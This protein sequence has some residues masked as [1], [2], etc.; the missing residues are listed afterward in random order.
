ML[1]AINGPARMQDGGQIQYYTTGSDDTVSPSSSAGSVGLDPTVVANLA[2]SLSLF[3]SGLAANIQLLKD[4]K[5]QIKLDTTNVNVTL[6]GESFLAS[7]SGALKSELMA[8][9]GEKIKVYKTALNQY[10]PYLSIQD[11]FKLF[12]F[13]FFIIFSIINDFF[14]KP[15]KAAVISTL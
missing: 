14:T 15:S 3:N 8:A 2:T 12:K 13:I 10:R 9:I 5:F 1:Q 6:N 7:L 4:M 11:A